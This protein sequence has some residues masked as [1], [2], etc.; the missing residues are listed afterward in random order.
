M[1]LCISALLILSLEPLERC[2]M[3]HTEREENGTFGPADYE[4]GSVTQAS[5]TSVTNIL[6]PAT[7]CFSQ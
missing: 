5:T 6:P 7:Y 1:L 4:L 3:R 2:P